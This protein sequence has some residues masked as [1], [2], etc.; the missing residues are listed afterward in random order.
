MKLS[1]KITSIAIALALILSTSLSSVFAADYAV[2]DTTALENGK[3]TV[4]TTAWQGEGG[5]LPGG[6]LSMCDVMFSGENEIEITD[7]NIIIT[8]YTAKPVPSPAFSAMGADGT[9]KNM[10]VV[11]E[12]EYGEVGSPDSIPA[13][14]T[15]YE[16]SGTDITTLPEKVYVKSQSGFGFIAG[17][18][19]TSQIDTITI[20]KTA[21]NLEKLGKGIKFGGYVNVAMNRNVLFYLQFT[22]FVKQDG[23][24]TEEPTVET[25]TSEVTATVLANK[26]TYTV[27]VPE[28][29]A[30]GNLSTSS[31]TSATYTV[32]ADMVLGN[33]SLV[34]VVEAAQNGELTLGESKITFSNDLTNAEFTQSGTRTG[35]LTIDPIGSDLAVGDYSGTIGFQISTK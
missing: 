1:K 7:S 28:T 30:L 2:E 5:K 23:G 19:Y 27:T 8:M 9:I 22:N 32:E 18:S 35:T 33:D 14:N 26:T 34:V 3:Y 16:T 29:I 15:K 20:P 24:D 4:S 11:D 6:E 10:F 13:E 12:S 17:N 25:R 21:V 31:S